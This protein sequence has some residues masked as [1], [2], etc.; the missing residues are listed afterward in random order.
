MDKER[1]LKSLDSI[2][3]YYWKDLNATPGKYWNHYAKLIYKQ[4]KLSGDIL[5]PSCFYAA[6][7]NG[8]PY[9]GFS[10]DIKIS[11]LE[12][13]FERLL[14]IMQN[15]MIKVAYDKSALDPIFRWIF[16]HKSFR[17]YK[18]L[19][20]EMYYMFVHWGYEFYRDHIESYNCLLYTS[21]SPRD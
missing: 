21:P 12:R 17:H 7:F 5:K 4:T 14:D 13:L 2:S 11:N 20:S 3:S 1:F 16:R 8:G 10:A 9:N 15:V 6:G 18:G 19:S